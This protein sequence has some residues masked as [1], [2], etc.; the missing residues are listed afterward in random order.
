M[1]QSTQREK[2]IG[3]CIDFVTFG[4][5]IDSTIIFLVTREAEM[6]LELRNTRDP[7]TKHINISENYR[8]YIY[9][10]SR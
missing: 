4:R 5:R 2:P 8:S 7:D 3:Q 9:I 6:Y 1:M 10:H